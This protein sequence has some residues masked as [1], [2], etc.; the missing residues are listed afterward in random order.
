[1]R[2]RPYRRP[3]SACGR[4]TAPPSGCWRA[5]GWRRITRQRR[6]TTMN[7][8]AE[9]SLRVIQV[10]PALNAGGVERGTVEFARELVK[11]GHES[12]VISSGGRQ[13]SLLEA[14]GSRHITLPVQRKS[15]WSL[16]QVRPMQRLLTAL[17]ADI[18]HVRS[19]LPA[20]IVWLAWRRMP[21]ASRPR[22]VSTF[23]GMYSVNFY[24]AIM[25]RAEHC[26]A[27]SE[28]VRRYVLAHY[29]LPPERLS[30]IPRGV[31]PSA[32]STDAATPA[33]C[34]ALYAQY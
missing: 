34:R 6:V 33:W 10:L 18:V 27:V 28:S 15:L 24:S 32:F 22:L 30:L 31:D 7:S 17:Q 21:R 25:A 23:H 16:R 5:P 11:A 3:S 9:R 4:P 12:L 19:R 14:Q 2:C 1:M 26:I 29:S 20:W 13:L 8:T